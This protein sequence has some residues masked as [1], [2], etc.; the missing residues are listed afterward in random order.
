[1]LWVCWGVDL[2]L[3]NSMDTTRV[4]TFYT[5]E[6]IMIPQGRGSQVLLLVGIIILIRVMNHLGTNHQ[7]FHTQ[8][9]RQHHHILI[10]E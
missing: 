10:M 8:I 9:M 3:V 1:M 6:H 4:D 7:A 2:D 5:G